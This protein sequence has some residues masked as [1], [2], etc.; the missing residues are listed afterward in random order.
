MIRIKVCGMRDPGNIRQIAV[1]GPDILGYIFFKGSKRYVGENPDNSL[2]TQIPETVE[3]AGVFVNELPEKICIAAGRY[4][5][6][7]IQLHGSETPHVCEALRYTGLQVIKAVGISGS[8][9][10]KA[11]EAYKNTCNYFLFD[12][13][14]VHHGGTGIKFNWHILND[15]KLDIPFFISGGISPDDTDILLRL[16]HPS[17]YG[18]D[19]NSRFEISPG[20]K[21]VQRVKEFIDKIRQLKLTD[22]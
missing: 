15:Y 7:I 14:S 13:A 6:Q 19:I 9:G 11:L 2:F 5:L 17:F 3:K 8:S 20:L 22:Q 21:D 1:A 10:F 18:V 12:T 4:N 16:N